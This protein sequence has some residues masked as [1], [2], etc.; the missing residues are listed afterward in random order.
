MLRK[1]LLLGL[2]LIS[3][4]AVLTGCSLRDH[5]KVPFM[6]FVDENFVPGKEL[7]EG[8]LN[9]PKKFKA[10]QGYWNLRNGSLSIENKSSFKVVF[11]YLPLSVIWDG[12]KRIGLANPH[13]GLAVKDA[14]PN[15]KVEKITL[16]SNVI[17][18]IIQTLSDSADTL[19]AYSIPGKSKTGIICV[20][21]RRNGAGRQKILRTSLPSDTDIFTPLLIWGNPENF[22][23]LATYDG[24]PNAS[25]L[26]ANVQG[27]RLNWRKAEGVQVGSFTAGAGVSLV[28]QG[29]KV[30]IGGGRVYILELT[31]KS[32]T[33]KEYEPAN[34]LIHKVEDKVMKA[35]DT[36]MQTTLSVFGDILMVTVPSTNES[37]TW[38]I[39][40]D[41]CIG[42]LYINNEEQ[43]I[44]VYQ[45]N[46]LVDEKT[47]PTGFS[48]CWFPNG[49]CGTW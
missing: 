45:G 48:G 42:T 3:A 49:G 9:Q 36:S 24:M 26:L 17:S 11:R 20:E 37:W 34:N 7:T 32:L 35:T 15:L 1:Y 31:G 23:V 12:G 4:F 33:V 10:V 41:R 2:C 19:I 16:P 8:G 44:K 25:L 46:K 27:E 47:L 38:A 22:N 18:G 14:R 13:P 29:P 28:K 43:K 40:N 5:N 39:Q 6:M 21:T 30:Y